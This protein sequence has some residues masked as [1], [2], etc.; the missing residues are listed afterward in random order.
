[1]KVLSSLHDAWCVITRRCDI[2]PPDDPDFQHK[3]Q[4]LKR[5]EEDANRNAEATRQRRTGNIMDDDVMGIPA[6]RR[7]GTP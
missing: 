4:T 7:R 3:I 1:M 5:Q 2:T 6:K